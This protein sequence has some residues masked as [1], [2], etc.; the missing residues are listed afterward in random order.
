MEEKERNPCKLKTV[1]RLSSIIRIRFGFLRT[2][3][4]PGMLRQN[5]IYFLPHNPNFNPRRDIPTFPRSCGRC[6]A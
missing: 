2:Y 6:H 5:W 1:Q 4:T 3:S